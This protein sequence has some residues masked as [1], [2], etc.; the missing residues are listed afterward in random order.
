MRMIKAFLSYSSKDQ[1]FVD[2]VAKALGRQYVI[3]DKYAFN[4]GIDLLESMQEGLSESTIFV[5]FASRSALQSQ[6]VNYELSEAH[7]LF[8]L[9]QLEQ[10]LTF[11]IDEKMELDDIPE[12]LRRAKIDRPLNPIDAATR[13]RQHI[14]LI[15]S[16]QTP[17]LFINR[18]REFELAAQFFAPASGEES[19]RYLLIIGLPGIGRRTFAS[20]IGRRLLSLSRTC[21]IDVDSGDNIQE[22]ALKI[23]DRAGYSATNADFIAQ[24]KLI[25]NLSEAEATDRILIDLRQLVAADFLPVLVDSGGMIDDY[26]KLSKPISSLL[27]NIRADDTL[28]LCLVTNRHPVPPP[29]SQL[30]TVT[31]PELAEPDMRVLVSTLARKRDLPLTA[32]ERNELADYLGGFPP[33]AYYAVEAASHQSVAIILARKKQLLDFTA[34]VFVRFLSTLRLSDHA[35]QILKVLATHNP[36]PGRVVEKV[37]GMSHD[38]V[39]NVLDELR[40]LS[41]FTVDDWGLF[42]PAAPIHESLLREFGWADTKQAKIVASE[43][44]EHVQNLPSEQPLLELTRTIFR[45]TLLSGQIVQP[46]MLRLS[47]DWIAI[48]EQKYHQGMY[49]DAVEFG[50]IAVQLRPENTNARSYL[51][52]SL[53]RENR[54]SEAEKEIDELQGYTRPSWI[55][56]LRGFLYRHRRQPDAAL[57][58]YRLAED[59]GFYG[60]AL[61]REIATCYFYLGDYGQAKAYINR[62]ASKAPDNRYV[63]DLKT[64]IAIRVR[65][66]KMAE[67]AL[68]NLRLVEMDSWYFH[69]E[70]SFHLAFGDLDQ[71]VKMSKKSIEAVMGKVPY[72]F[73]VQ[74]INSSIESPDFKSA[75]FGISEAKRHYNRS[76]HDTNCILEARIELSRDRCS[77]AEQLL[78]GVQDRTTPLFRQIELDIYR[79]LLSDSALDFEIRENLEEKVDVLERQLSTWNENRRYWPDESSR[80]AAVD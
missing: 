69:R 40:S 26:G 74:L 44:T 19:P 63:L 48:T 27:A 80:N 1:R 55:H 23:A 60:L 51:I 57:D 68:G 22:L 77:D 75:E 46:D 20:E 2:Q 15:Q 73:Y 41:I 32:E 49:A 12:W 8:S 76:R 67:D 4:T 70:S 10:T 50:K 37:T 30:P 35:K 62:A 64:Q 25:L 11:I 18:S 21:V 28:Y 16:K 14:N 29:G 47:S 42:R 78:Q 52:R 58:E 61:L 38:E 72:E 17:N 65:D 5:F 13:I 3:F 24:S 7:R 39:I 33:A 66:K 79:C 34:A 43:L 36:L 59:Q 56:F 45:A 31:V 54:W 71:A 6:F 9:Q 53:V